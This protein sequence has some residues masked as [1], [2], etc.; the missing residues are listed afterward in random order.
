MT[1]EHV[2]AAISK[3]VSKGILL[4]QQI[5]VLELSEGSSYQALH[6]GSFADEGPILDD[7]HHTVMPANNATFHGL[8]H[9]IYLSDFRKTEPSK[10]RRILRQPIRHVS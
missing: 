7:L 5:Q 2:Q 1:E 4:A 8:H 3:A 9:E 10:L 6:I